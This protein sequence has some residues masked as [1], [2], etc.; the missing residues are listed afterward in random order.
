MQGPENFLQKQTKRPVILTTKSQF[1][2]QCTIPI[3]TVKATL[4]QC[5]TPMILLFPQVASSRGM[6]IQFI[7]GYQMHAKNDGH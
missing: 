6:D 5:C 4:K 1:V 3:L 7:V 2:T